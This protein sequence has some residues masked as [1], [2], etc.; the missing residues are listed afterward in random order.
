MGLLDIPPELTERI[1]QLCEPRDLPALRLVNREVG[2][3]VIRTFTKVHFEK[4]S[5]LLCYE[6]GLQRLTRIAEHPHFGK[7][8]GSL[9]FYIDEIPEADHP[10][11]DGNDS[12]Q[13]LDRMSDSERA[14]RILENQRYLELLQQQ[15]D[16][17]Q[18]DT[19]LRLLTGIFSRLKGFGKILD[20]AIVDTNVHDVSPPDAEEVDRD[21]VTDEREIVESTNEALVVRDDDDERRVEIVLQALASSAVAVDKFAIDCRSW[22]WSQYS[23]GGPEVLPHAHSLFAGLRYLHLAL[24]GY[25]GESKAVR[26]RTIEVFAAAQALEVLSLSVASPVGDDIDKADLD[27]PWRLELFANLWDTKFA[28]LRYL[29]LQR[30]LLDIEDISRFLMQHRTLK[31]VAFRGCHIVSVTANG[32]W[33]LEQKKPAPDSKHDEKIARL[34]QQIGH[35][36][37]V[38][39]EG[40]SVRAW[41]VEEV[42]VVEDE[43]VEDGEET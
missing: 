35:L 42:E 36:P 19:D 24:G 26:E 3:R 15:R 10:S 6:P 29:T 41:Q 13:T 37:Q 17:R 20:V 25:I 40:C 30:F 39:V 7:A 1:A 5:C 38:R 12:P 34:I 28:A 21:W 8:F 43:A 16:L 9:V 32:A 18:S 2:S 14:E 4:R 22:A 33:L 31:A 27:S 11:R 23:L